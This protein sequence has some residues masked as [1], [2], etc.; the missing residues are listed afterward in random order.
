MSP[1]WQAWRGGCYHAQAGAMHLDLRTSAG[2]RHR[3]GWRAGGTYPDATAPLIGTTFP[4]FEPVAYRDHS[5]MTL[6]RFSNMS[7]RW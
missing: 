2:R 6:R 1:S 5:V 3:A 4:P 7:E